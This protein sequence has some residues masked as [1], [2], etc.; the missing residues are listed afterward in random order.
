MEAG[1]HRFIRLL[2]LF[3]LAISVAEAT[4]AM[5]AA[6][7][8]GV[9]EDRPTCREALRLALVKDRRDDEI[10]DEVFAAFFALRP[11]TR[12]GSDE[13]GHAQSETSVGGVLYDLFHRYEGRRIITTCFASHIHRVQQIADAAIA[14]D[15]DKLHDLQVVRRTLES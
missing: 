4:D 13:H 10:F 8:P 2:R 3:G 9:L 14:F 11:V 6:A 7:Q 15:V 5:R 12:S 1:L